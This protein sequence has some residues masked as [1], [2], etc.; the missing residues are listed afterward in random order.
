MKPKYVALVGG[1]VMIV[2]SLLP[3]VSVSSMF[4]TINKNGIEG[5]GIFTLIC[6]VAVILASIVA[7][8]K[9]GKPSSVL[10]VLFGLFG[11]ILAVF[12]LANVGEATRT[13][14]GESVFAAVGIGIYVTLIGAVVAIVGGL[15]KST[16]VTPQGEAITPLAATDDVVTPIPPSSNYAAKL[17]ELKELL[18]QNLITQEEYN[19]KRTELLKQM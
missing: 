8:E 9:P 11:G 16:S 3:W 2:G 14:S 10:A 5:D 13:I 6:G 18:S 4:G 1:I 12:T 19:A 15:M 7:K 17:T